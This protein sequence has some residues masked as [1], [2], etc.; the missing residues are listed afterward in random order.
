LIIA[1]NCAV[2]QGINF[3]LFFGGGLISL[4]NILQ[5]NVIAYLSS[6]YLQA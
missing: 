6:R 5:V 1:A 3:S 2:P 4:K